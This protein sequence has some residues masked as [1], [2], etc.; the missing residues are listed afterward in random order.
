[1]QDRCAT[2]AERVVAKLSQCM[3]AARLHRTASGNVVRS[4][5]IVLALAAGLISPLACAGC[6]GS[7]VSV[8]VLG[9]GGPVADDARASS[10]YVLWVDGRA[11]VLIDAGGGTFVRFGESKARIEDLDLIAITH[12]HADHVG[13]LPAL[14][15]SG[16]FSDRS[17]ALAISGP[18]GGEDFPSLEE[19]LADEFDPKRGAFRY[20]SGALDG[21]AGLFKLEP[22]QVAAA[23]RTPVV[24][25]RSGELAIEAVGVPHG[26]VPALGYVI[27]IRGRT[28]AFSGDQ[29]GSDD[30][31]WSLA[32]DADLL[33]MDSAIPEKPDEVA[34]RLHA[35]PGTIGRRAADAGIR[36]VVLSHLM[37]RSLAVLDANLAIIRRHFKGRLDVASDL[38]C[39]RVDARAASKEAR[40]GTSAGAP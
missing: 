12:F 14:I 33:I 37:A 40:A 4:F 35:T 19:F 20:L 24:V 10:G 23:G 17:H 30:A 36:H 9:S 32:K 3:I 34:G 21:S 11:R 29:N 2:T 31:F 8:Q 5:P 1:M 28:A 26:P 16:F 18:D 7:G 13:D 25:F 6:G 15:K 38:A 39:Y 22:R 27:R